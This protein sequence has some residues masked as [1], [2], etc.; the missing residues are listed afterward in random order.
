MDEK[1]DEVVNDSPKTRRKGAFAIRSKTTYY[2]LL[3]IFAAVFLLSAI[4][5]GGYFF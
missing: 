2:V 3:A 5:L 4:Y 1:K